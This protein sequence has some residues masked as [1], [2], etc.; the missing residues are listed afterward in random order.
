MFD[1]AS[2]TVVRWGDD[3]EVER[4]I[5]VVAVPPSAGGPCLSS[6]AAGAGALWVTITSSL[7]NEAE[8]PALVEPCSP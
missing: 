6:I 4:S 5:R 2:G 7:I 8:G 3:W 1:N